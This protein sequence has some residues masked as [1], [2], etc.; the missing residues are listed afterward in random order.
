MRLELTVRHLVRNTFGGAIGGPIW[1]DKLFFFY[2]FESQ[3]NATAQSVVQVVPLRI[4]VRAYS[5]THTARIPI[6]RP[7]SPS[8][9]L[10][11]MEQVYSTT[12]I[13]PAALDCA[14]DAAAKYPV[15]R[16]YSWRRFE[17]QWISI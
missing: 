6:A 8:L 7:V 9:N 5:I 13:N 12:G 10:V 15:E 3:H 2:S 1:K 16:H 17:H 14:D 4:L 11:Q